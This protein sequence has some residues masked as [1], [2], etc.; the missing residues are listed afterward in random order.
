MSAHISRLSG[1][2]KELKVQWLQTR[3]SWRDAKALEFEAKYMDELFASVE[4]ALT[5]MEQIDKLSSRIKKDC[6]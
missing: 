3:E 2:T 5:V 6:E 1:V 4:R